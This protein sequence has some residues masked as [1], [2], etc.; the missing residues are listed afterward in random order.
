MGFGGQPTGARLREHP[1][2]FKDTLKRE[3]EEG[4][5]LTGADVARA[6]AAHT[7]VWRRFQTFLER[8]EYFILP[9]TQLPPFDI[10]TP[11]PT[12]IAGVNFDNYIDWMKS[13]WYISVTGNPA[14]SV[15]GGFT[16]E[17]LP[18]GVEIVGRRNQDFAVLQLVH[19]FSNRPRDSAR[20][21]RPFHRPFNR[22]TVT[23]AAAPLRYTLNIPEGSMRRILIS[24]SLFA[25]LSFTVLFTVRS[26][27][28][29]P[30]AKPKMAKSEAAGASYGNAE[31]ISENELK[32]YLYFLASDQLEGRNLPSRGFDTAALY[33]ASHLAEWGLKPG[34]STANTNGPLQPY[35][36]P[37]EM[38]SKSVAAD[39]NCKV[40]LTAPAGRGGG[41]RR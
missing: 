19:A 3:I 18:V 10:N 11:Y 16:P 1:D 40:T 32:V 14:A 37:M 27:K 31:S 33:I 35:M 28:S 20:N 34:G 15:P 23:R 24:S 9:T 36:M 12:Q 30:Q 41:L 13:C 6:E 7:Q 4:L 26:A 5:R 8:Y 21:A 22:F 2:A 17:G 38:V 39:D 25:V 29:A